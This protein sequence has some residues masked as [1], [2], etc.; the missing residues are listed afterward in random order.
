MK[1]VF[2]GI[3]PTGEIHIGNYLGAVKNYVA[4]QEK[5]ECIYCIVDL[6]AITIEYDPKEMQERIRNC[7]VVLF[8]CGID[9]ERC[10]L[11]VQSKVPEHT[12]LAWIL[13]SVTPIGDLERMTQ[14][15]EKAKQHRE[16]INAGLL[17]YPA[18]QTADIILYK[19]EVVPVG[20]DQVQHIELAR[21]IVRKFHNRYGKTFPE[22]KALTHEAKR[23]LGLD[24]KS[25]MS[26]S[27]NNYISLMD[28][29]EKVW[30]KV[31]PAFTD[32]ARLRRNDPGNP[33]ICNIYALDKFF[34]PEEDLQRI[35]RECRE[36]TIGC[37]EHKK[38]FAEN[39]SAHLAPIQERAKE[40][41]AN[42]E[43]VREILDDAAGKC[44]LIA[45]ETMREVKAKMGLL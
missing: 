29:P 25:K 32:P 30:N 1:R 38:A 21:E 44:R 28:P 40:L 41:L 5:Y 16:N 7:A 23:I 42:P 19:A 37:V 17:T 12:E 4:L 33:D 34:T 13:N 9:P 3:Q 6:H 45:K 43:R 22:P 10:T 8:A 15:K 35:D 20:E 39:V 2:S 24:G 18:L 11:F 31:K 26:K 36:G 14:F 27:M